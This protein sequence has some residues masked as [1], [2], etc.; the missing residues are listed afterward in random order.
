[1][2]GA[3]A[4][5]ICALPLLQILSQLASSISPFSL[6]DERGRIS[7]T[8]RFSGVQYPL[9]RSLYGTELVTEVTIVGGIDRAR[10][11]C[12]RTIDTL[13][14]SPREDII[15]SVTGLVDARF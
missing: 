11:S 9:I 3:D 5:E 8:L 13:A 14:F 4:W 2:T 1:V 15:A 10:D 12:M 6:Q 7:T